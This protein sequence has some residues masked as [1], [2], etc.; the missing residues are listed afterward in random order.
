MIYGEGDKAFRRL[1]EQI[2]KDIGDESILAWG[3]QSRLPGTHI[4]RD[5]GT[6]LAPS[7]LYFATSGH[8]VVPDLSAHSTFEVRGGNLRLTVAL[9]KLPG[10]LFGLLKCGPSRELKTVVG[11]PLVAVPGGQSN[12][13][14]RPEGGQPILVSHPGATAFAT[15]IQI[16]LD[17]GH[18]SASP[19]AETCWIHIPKSVPDLQLIEV[20]PGGSWHKER[21]LIEVPVDPSNTPKILARFRDCSKKSSD[22]V[23]VL[24]V[25][26]D[27]VPRCYLMVLS[28]R[29]TLEEMACHREAWAG[30]VLGRMSANNH[31]I[32]LGLTLETLQASSWH[33]RFVL[34]PVVLQDIPASTVNATAVLQLS[35]ANALLANLR[36]I[37]KAQEHALQGLRLMIGEGNE[38]RV[39]KQ[40]KLEEVRA[41]IEALQ[42]EERRLAEEVHLEL[43]ST[44]QLCE[45]RQ[46]LQRAGLYTRDT[47]TWVGRFIDV[48]NG[49]E[50]A[51]PE[52]DLSRTA[53]H[54]LA[55]AVE[56]GY[57]SLVHLLLDKAHHVNQWDFAGRT[58]LHHAVSR[59]REE[60]VRQ[61]LKKG[62][63]IHRPDTKG[64]TPL[65]IAA[66]R[67]LEG[68]ARLLVANGASLRFQTEDGITPLQQAIRSGH[69][70][71]AELLTPPGTIA[72]QPALSGPKR[73]SLTA[74]SARQKS[75]A[76]HK[77]GA[78]P[79]E[80]RS[81]RT[82][83]SE[84]SGPTTSINSAAAPSALNVRPPPSNRLERTDASEELFNLLFPLPEASA[85]EVGM[86]PRR[87]LLR[88]EVDPRG[89][90]S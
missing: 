6:A 88:R 12:Q 24:G 43:M 63:D 48:Y 73:E 44:N 20:Y 61:L 67:G 68:I 82:L 75:D 28:R 86:I 27:A 11:I 87:R 41:K 23:A 42:A 26:P 50:S 72:P 14:L 1:Q 89:S 5:V 85:S 16:Q 56:K 70:H 55:F 79:P 21:A 64:L 78:M 35:G 38:K 45:Q 84:A 22:F 53:S 59:G 49:K 80:A 25:H 60:L 52:D 33:R 34:K 83:T 31:V 32:T 18:S 69:S 4:P 2:M 58:A 15:S 74:P 8:I 36:Q 9:Y 40:R 76:F 13:Y 30:M 46:H 65:H 39:Q 77:T 54:M 90:K 29:T 66:D 37:D 17:V 57:D 47:I 62:A 51:A 19:V 3:F 81:S 7:P 10:A 71:L